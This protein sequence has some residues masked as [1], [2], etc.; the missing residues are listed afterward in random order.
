MKTFWTEIWIALSAYKQAHKAISKYKLYTYILIPGILN[1]LLIVG[2]IV[3][4]IVKWNSIQLDFLTQMNCN[5][6]TWWCRFIQNQQNNYTWARG[7]IMILISF[8]LYFYLYK[9]VI[10]ILFAPF[11]SLM[12]AKID[13]QEN[14]NTLPFSLKRLFKEIIR[15]VAITFY[16]AF[17]EIF[18]VISSFSLLIIPTINVLQPL[19][20]WL[21][22]AYFYGANA[23]DYTLENKLYPLKKSKI[24]LKKHR[25]LNLGIGIGTK[26]LLFLP[27]IGWLMAPAYA[28]AAAYYAHK[29][30]LHE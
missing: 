28:V 17:W 19:I 24:Y 8:I 26:L 9:Y 11:F 14:P 2:L 6:D 1:V 22:G 30:V 18:L 21:I 29:K 13:A 15:A 25:G 16:F 7:I 3:F 27:L 5:Q 4:F 23:M 12:I 20:V 10:L